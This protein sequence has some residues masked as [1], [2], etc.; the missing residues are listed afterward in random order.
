M[1]DPRNPATQAAPNEQ[2]DF[3]ET[4]T[5]AA[6]CTDDW[7]EEIQATETEVRGDDCDCA[8]E[9]ERRIDRTNMWTDIEV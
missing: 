6:G 1:N 7:T 4:D 2:I 5:P 9:H 3:A 8:G